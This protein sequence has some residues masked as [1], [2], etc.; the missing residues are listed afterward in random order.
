MRR[1]ARWLYVVALVADFALSSLALSLFRTRSLTRSLAHPPL[2]P[3]PVD[4]LL[5]LS[6]F[7]SLPRRLLRLQHHA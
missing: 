7:L 3:P 1:Y 6:K 5:Y 2:P 4:S